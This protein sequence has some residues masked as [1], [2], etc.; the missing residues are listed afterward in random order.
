VLK[1]AEFIL[2]DKGKSEAFSCLMEKALLFY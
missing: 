1:D 2:I